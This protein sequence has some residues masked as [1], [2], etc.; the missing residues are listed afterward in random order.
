MDHVVTDPTLISCV[1]GHFCKCLRRQSIFED[2]LGA[3]NSLKKHTALPM[4]HIHRISIQIVKKGL[5]YVL[6]QYIKY[7]KTNWELNCTK[8]SF[9]QPQ[10]RKWFKK[11]FYIGGL[12]DK[13]SP[14]KKFDWTGV[15]ITTDGV[16]ASIHYDRINLPAQVL[17][18]VVDVSESEDLFP[19]VWV[20]NGDDDSGDDILPSPSLEIDT[21]IAMEF[22]DGEESAGDGVFAEGSSGGNNIPFPTNN[23][24]INNLAGMMEEQMII[25][26]IEM[27]EDDDEND[28]DDELGKN[29]ICS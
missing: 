6:K 24:I 26:N 22:D 21:D 1:I 11:L 10:F 7:Y 9:K 29:H 13:N 18:Q 20:G 2:V 28:D 19:E 27:F 14:S 17:A 8:D 4:F 12:I 15:A 5:Y 3:P 23:E 25:E 16:K